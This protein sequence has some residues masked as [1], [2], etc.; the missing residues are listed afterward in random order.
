VRKELVSRK[1]GRSWTRLM[2]FW[3]KSASTGEAEAGAPAPEEVRGAGGGEAM[4]SGVVG[5]LGLV[6]GW[7]RVD[8]GRQADG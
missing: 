6:G 2:R 7:A 4:D 3:R 1:G 5:F 8:A